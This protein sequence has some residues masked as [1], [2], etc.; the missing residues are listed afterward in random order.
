VVATKKRRKIE[1]GNVFYHPVNKNMKFLEGTKSSIGVY[2]SQPED[3][4]SIGQVIHIS[5]NKSLM[6]AYYE[7]LYLQKDINHDLIK[8][9]LKKKVILIFST[10][11]DG[12]TC[13]WTPYID[14]FDIPNDMPYQ[15]YVK[16]DRKTLIDY[17]EKYEKT[18][19]REQPY[20][21]NQ[22]RTKFLNYG[23]LISLGGITE[24]IRYYNK[25]DTRW[26]INDGEYIPKDKGLVW[27]IFPEH[28][29]EPKP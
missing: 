8:K 26:K 12:F 24:E 25:L 7:G 11:R 9:V 13:G 27:K 20:F 29:P 1:I 15:V 18:L 28:Y 3:L 17:S 23:V 22:R 21:K 2:D 6:V 10:F 19:S 4:V 16:N 5:S 14:K